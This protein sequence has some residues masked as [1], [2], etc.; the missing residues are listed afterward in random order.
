[1]S[2]LGCFQQEVHREPPLPNLL[3]DEE[4]HCLIIDVSNY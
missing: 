2:Y 3:K 1:M 4:H